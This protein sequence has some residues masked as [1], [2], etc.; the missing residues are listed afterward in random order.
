MRDIN[1]RRVYIHKNSVFLNDEKPSLD[2]NVFWIKKE[3]NS[4]AILT[5]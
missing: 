2:M 4:W 3:N 5:S 1:H